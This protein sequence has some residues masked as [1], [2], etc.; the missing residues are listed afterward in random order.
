MGKA[1]VPEDYKRY[2]GVRPLRP[3]STQKFILTSFGQIY[4]GSLSHPEVKEKVETAKLVLSIGAIKSDFN[5]GNFTY[6][7]SR[8]TTVEVNLLIRRF[9][10]CLSYG[11]CIPT[12]RACSMHSILGLE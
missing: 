10:G 6:R 8:A 5:T 3:V 1:A 12:T 11:S 7:T 9:P 2:G 4:V